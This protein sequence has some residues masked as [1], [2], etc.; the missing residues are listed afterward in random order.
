MHAKGA[1]VSSSGSVYRGI[2]SS[3]SSGAKGSAKPKQCVKCEGKG[4]TMVTTAVS[5][6]W[7]IWLLVIICCADGRI[8]TRYAQGDVHRMRGAWRKA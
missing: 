6:V 3:G 7:F 5:F 4:W 2:E 8:K 1:F